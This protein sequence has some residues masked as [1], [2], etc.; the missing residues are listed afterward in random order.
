MAAKK[1]AKCMGI[2]K[3]VLTNDLKYFP[4]LCAPNLF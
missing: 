1:R 3:K 2:K 4:K